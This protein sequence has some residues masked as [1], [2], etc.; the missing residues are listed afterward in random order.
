METILDLFDFDSDFEPHPL[1]G[2]TMTRDEL[3]KAWNAAEPITRSARAAADMVLIDI[4]QTAYGDWKLYQ[5]ATT[6]RYYN[7]Y[8]SIGD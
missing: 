5:D 3:N 6:D 4:A 2:E 7:E 8:E 1:P